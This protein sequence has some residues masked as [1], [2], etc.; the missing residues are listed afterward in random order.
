[1]ITGVTLHDIN[2]S[3]KTEGSLLG[4]LTDYS[5]T[6]SGE[7][8]NWTFPSTLSP[9]TSTKSTVL[10]RNVIPPLVSSVATIFKYYRYDNDAKSATDGE[11]LS[12][13]VSELPL[14]IARAEEVSKVDIGFTQAPESGD[15]GQQGGGSHTANI[16]SS[17][18]LRFDPSETGTEIE[19]EPCS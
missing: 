17:V 15:T 19:N 16:A 10:A 5:F 3:P 12:I 9:A 7:A 13:P 14:T 11:L 8:P 18:A 2:W 4:T 6:G 1:V